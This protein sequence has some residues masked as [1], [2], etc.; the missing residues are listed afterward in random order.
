MKWSVLST[1]GTR[2]FQGVVGTEAGPAW[3]P[4][5]VT[6]DKTALLYAVPAGAGEHTMV[7]AS[8]DGSPYQNDHQI[9]PVPIP[10]VPHTLAITPQLIDFL[11][12]A[13]IIRFPDHFV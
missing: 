5:N 11:V 1:S 7:P 6:V 4:G 10:H 13:A 3:A 12:Q 2:T 8:H 9:S